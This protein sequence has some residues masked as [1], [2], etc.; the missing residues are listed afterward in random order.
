MG[1]SQRLGMDLANA[2]N[3][4]RPRKLGSWDSFASEQEEAWRLLMDS[5]L[6]E[7]KLFTSLHALEEVG[8]DLGRRPIGSEL[9]L[10]YFL[11]RTVEDH[12]LRII[13][14]LYKD[15]KLRHTFG[16]KGL[17]RFEPHSD[18]LSPEQELE[19][20][21]RNMEIRGRP[22]RRHSPRIAARYQ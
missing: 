2:A 5:S 13:E 18:T 6:M 21:L 11:C 9:D 3:K 19:K 10:I 20:R 7:D 8:E 4:L 16:L 14:E 12:F 1:H 17:I 22:R 15:P